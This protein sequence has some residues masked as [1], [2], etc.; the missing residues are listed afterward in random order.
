MEREVVSL[1]TT[2]G[3]KLAVEV[4]EPARGA[5]RGTVLLLHAMMASRRSFDRAPGGGLAGALVEQGLRT[6]ALDFRG[7]GE[8]TPLAGAGARYD[9]DDLVAGDLP[10]LYGAASARWPRDPVT[11]VGHSLGGYAAMAAAATC[12]FDVAAIVAIATNVWLPS[13]EPNPWV[14]ARKRAV[15]ETLSAAARMRG[16]L[17]ARTLRLGSNDESR[18]FIDGWAN[19]WRDD[20]WTSAD[21]R[22]D[23]AGAMSKLKVPLLF[24]ASQG[25]RFACPPDSA[26]RFA[27]LAPAEHVSFEIIRAGDNG[28]PA[29]GHMEMVTTRT[30]AASAWSKIG[31]FCAQRRTR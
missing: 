9:F 27:S 11:V 23:Y 16:Y 1:T 14:S 30:V 2:S 18:A 26:R 19:W 29:P 22:T 17:P 3:H 15:V 20:E 21:L 8:S 13:L 7:H 28:A 6:L 10:A 4:C 31:A 24:V 25:D 12:D 5:A